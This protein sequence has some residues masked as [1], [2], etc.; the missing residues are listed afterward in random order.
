[1]RDF[2]RPRLSLAISLSLVLSCLPSCAPESTV[3]G[4]WWWPAI[5]PAHDL[6][7][8]YGVRVRG[9][10]TRVST[11]T[12]PSRDYLGLMFVSSDSPTS[13]S[14]YAGYL[15]SLAE[16]Q[17]W[18][19]E[20]TSPEVSS[21]ERP[22]NAQILGY[23]CQSIAEASLEAFGGDGSYR[24]LHA[25]MDLS[26]GGP[27]ATGEFG[28]AP[29]GAAAAQFGGAELLTSSTYVA[30]LYERTVHGEGI[31]PDLSS[32]G[33][34]GDFDPL[35]ACPAIFSNLLDNNSA[36]P[37][38]QVPVL[39][40]AAHRYYHHYRSQATL[41][42]PTR[43]SGAEPCTGFDERDLNVS[44]AIVARDYGDLATLG[45][46]VSPSV[47]LEVAGAVDSFPYEQ[48]LVSTQAEPVAVEACPELGDVLP[49]IW[50]ELASLGWAAAATG[51]DDDSAN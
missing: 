13:C 51:D 45:G 17:R 42:W 24:A 4:S 5:D 31:L 28:A 3:L 1:M 32:D 27:L 12:L 46:E 14:A 35:A 47:F 44:N 26:D 33:N 37:D 16:T 6:D 21:D 39:N 9:Y 30:R 49:F 25:I 48:V 8:G 18:F 10:A 38:G 15:S 19:D 2:V 23:V 7:G 40:A 29:K 34:A 36:I 11:D 20:V 50:P 22:S 43:E 41:C